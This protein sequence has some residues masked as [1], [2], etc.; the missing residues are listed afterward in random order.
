MKK[1]IK[2]LCSITIVS[3][4][5]G[6][7]LTGCVTK[8][9]IKSID[10]DQSG[11][12]IWK[13]DEIRGVSQSTT[14]TGVKTWTLIGKNN[15]Y[16]LSDETSQGKINRNFTTFLNNPEL[17]PQAI[18][19][20][21]WIQCYSQKNHSNDFMCYDVNIF[22]RYPDEVTPQQ[23]NSLKK[24][25]NLNKNVP[26]TSV[27]LLLSGSIKSNNEDNAVVIPFKNKSTLVINKDKS[28]FS[29]KYLLVPFS[30]VADVITAPFQA[31]GYLIIINSL[32]AMRY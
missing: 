29:A 7:G 10:E 5:S 28:S 19:I 4:F 17:S 8:S 21:S 1:F 22:Y 26:G 6:F 2:A 27:M 12:V 16:Q 32:P 9:L 3:C 15:N 23:K 31:I 11:T 20:S 13:K 14:N 24:A 18:E 25:F 30:V